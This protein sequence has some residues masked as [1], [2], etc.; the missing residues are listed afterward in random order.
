[1]DSEFTRVWLRT[2]HRCRQTSTQSLEFSKRFNNMN[3][4]ANEAILIG[5][6]AGDA[7]ENPPSRIG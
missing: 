5:Y 6:A 3:G 1:M 4:Q 7:L 2:Q